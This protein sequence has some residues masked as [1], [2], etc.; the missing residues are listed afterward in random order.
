V[1]FNISNDV[2]VFSVHYTGDVEKLYNLR[3][4]FVEQRQTAADT[5]TKPHMQHMQ[6]STETDLAA[7]FKHVRQWAQDNTRGV[8]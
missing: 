8:Q 3:G 5:W 2:S 1:A 7:E 6:H 4:Q